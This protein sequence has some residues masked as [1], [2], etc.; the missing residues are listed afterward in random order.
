MRQAQLFG[1]QVQG[2]WLQR[3]L[4]QR[5]IHMFAGA[6]QRLHMA[7]AGD[8]QAFR[9]RMP[10]D[11][12]QQSLAQ[13]IQALAR[14]GGEAQD[15]GGGGGFFGSGPTGSAIGTKAG[16]GSSSAWKCD[17]SSV[18]GAPETA[19]A[20]SLLS[21]P[22]NCTTTVPVLLPLEIVGVAL[23][24][25]NK[26]LATPEMLAAV[27]KAKADIIAGTL[28]VHDYMSDEKCPY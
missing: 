4:L 3:G 14:F 27:D 13:R 18:S 24:D 25:N 9:H 8:E 6:A 12:L 28:Q 16:R 26:A 22:L 10:A 17:S 11:L 20:S 19:R 15:A 1:H 5:Q 2:R 23:D 21:A 7:L